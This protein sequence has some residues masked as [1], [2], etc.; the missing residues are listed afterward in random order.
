LNLEDILINYI[1]LFLKIR[2]MPEKILPRSITGFTEY[3]K[4]AFNKAQANVEYY[5]ISPEKMWVISP[6]I[7]AYVQAEAV[8]ANPD[9]ATAGARRARN[10]ARRA[11]EPAWRIFLNECIRYNSAVPTADLEVFGIKK[12]DSVR[13]QVGVPD[14]VPVIAAKTVGVRRMEVDVLN[15]ETG[16]KKKP[17]FAA[18]S[19]IYL[20]VTEPGQT[21]QNES[22]YRKLDFSSH[23][24]HVLEFPLEQ[25][26]KQA[27]I[28]ARY[29]NIHGKEG[30]EGA[31]E[32]AI[33]G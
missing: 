11:L 23:C 33:I 6:L 31:A 3:I 12:R 22:E 24:H 30:P 13:T 28:Y 14:I 25:L 4:I 1:V 8:A 18:G 32:V 10:A 5:H 19:Y 16:K 9:T 27:N 26:A 17:K 2:I 29:S 20:A 15:S 21:P 7:D